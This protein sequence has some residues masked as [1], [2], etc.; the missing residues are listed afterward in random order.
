MN[1]EGLKLEELLELERL[2]LLLE[3]AENAS[4]VPAAQPAEP[5]AIT[6]KKKPD[7]IPQPSR[8]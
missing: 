1:L 8:E 2:L 7:P 5:R 6:E 3:R 4:S